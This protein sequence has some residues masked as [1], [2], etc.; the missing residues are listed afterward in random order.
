[1]IDAK[2]RPY[3]MAK[4]VERNSGE[5]ASYFATSSVASGVMILVTS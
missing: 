2:D 3:D 1:M 4:V 5:Y